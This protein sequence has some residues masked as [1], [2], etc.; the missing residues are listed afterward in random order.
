[1]L[2]VIV[3]PEW[4]RAKRLP[5]QLHNFKRDQSVDNSLIR[6]IISQLAIIARRAPCRAIAYDLGRSTVKM[7]LIRGVRP[8]R[9][10]WRSCRVHRGRAATPTTVRRRRRAARPRCRL[11]RD[12]PTPCPARP[13]ADRD[14]R[15]SLARRLHAVRAGTERHRR[16]GGRRRQGRQGPAREGLRLSPTSPSARRSIRRRRCSARARSPSCSPGPR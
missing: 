6:I 9:H 4:G 10:C 11:R 12:R 5:G 8:V 13:T 1:M 3:A 2:R 16:R 15:R 14:R 7:H